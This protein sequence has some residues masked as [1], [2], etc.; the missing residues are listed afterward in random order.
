MSESDSS[1]PSLHEYLDGTDSVGSNHESVLPAK[2]NRQQTK[3]QIRGKVWAFH[4]DIITDLLPDDSDL[5]GFDDSDEKANFLRLQSHLKARLGDDFKV[6][7]GIETVITYFVIFCELLGV[8]QL[9]PDSDNALKNKIKIRGFLQCPKTIAITKLQ[10]CLPSVA[11][12]ITGNWERCE[13]VLVKNQLFKDC[14]QESDSCPWMLLHETG[15]L[16][17]KTN[18]RKPRRPTKKVKFYLEWWGGA[19]QASGPLDLIIPDSA[20]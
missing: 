2:R 9:V 12:F 5:P 13:G 15:K 10:K 8:L 1:E 3:K 18:S 11:D 14:V 6:F 17:A 19:T 4:G 20:L 16:A 7:F